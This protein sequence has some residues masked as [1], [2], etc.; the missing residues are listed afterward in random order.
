MTDVP[1][2][3]M[4]ANICFFIDLI[5]FFVFF[6]FSIETAHCR[7]QISNATD[8]FYKSTKCSEASFSEETEKKIL[9]AE[10]IK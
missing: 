3:T 6:V 9:F 2:A 8:K 10:K 7:L 5:S 4:I 1:G